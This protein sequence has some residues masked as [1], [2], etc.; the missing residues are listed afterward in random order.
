VVNALVTYW[1]PAQEQDIVCIAGS[2][3]VRSELDV[4]K[5]CYKLRGTNGDW[6]KVSLGSLFTKEGVLKAAILEN[7][8]KQVL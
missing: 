3:C 2:L 7:L 5:M 6:K 4:D 8:V 1:L